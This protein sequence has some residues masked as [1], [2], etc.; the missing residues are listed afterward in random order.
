M[1]DH[2]ID[3]THF[4]YPIIKLSEKMNFEKNKR[5]RL[6]SLNLLQKCSNLACDECQGF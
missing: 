1:F 5:L 4:Q 2:D 6:Q 3:T